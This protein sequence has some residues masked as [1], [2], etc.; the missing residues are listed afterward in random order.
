MVNLTDINAVKKAL[1]YEG[2]RFNKCPKRLWHLWR[3]VVFDRDGARVGIAAERQLM[4]RGRKGAGSDLNL[5]I[6]SRERNKGA[7]A[8]ISMP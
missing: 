4:F 2:H 7:N 8:T 6:E 5:T 1:G 3:A